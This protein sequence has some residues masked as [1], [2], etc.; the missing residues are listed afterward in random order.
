MGRVE[1]ETRLRGDNPH[2]DSWCRGTDL[3]PFLALLPLGGHDVPYGL[4][5][6]YYERTLA[7]HMAITD[8]Q[9]FAGAGVLGAPPDS[10]VQFPVR[11]IAGRSGRRGVRPWPGTGRAW[12]FRRL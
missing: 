6:S 2:T 9:A 10:A 4:S 11:G 8:A 3:R 1:A 12:G 5:H 7:V